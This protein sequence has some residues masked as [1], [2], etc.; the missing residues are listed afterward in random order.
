MGAFDDAIFVSFSWEADDGTSLKLELFSHLWSFGGSLHC[1]CPVWA[2]LLWVDKGLWSPH[3]SDCHLSLQTFLTYKAQVQ[4]WADTDDR[5]QTAV[6]LPA[7]TQ[8]TW[9]EAFWVAPIPR[10]KQK[11][12][13]GFR[14]QGNLQPVSPINGPS[15]LPAC[16]TFTT[17][18]GKESRG[19]S[20]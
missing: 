10:T 18:G 2:F 20:F 4:Y 15:S 3:L 19:N 11:F 5:V 16:A 17:G 9:Q 14:G 7:V 1:C 6:Q 8:N 13:L 12:I